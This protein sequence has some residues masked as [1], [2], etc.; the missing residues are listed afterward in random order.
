MLKD[1]MFQEMF[2][3]LELN[4]FEEAKILANYQNFADG[5]VATI[6]EMGYMSTADAV[7]KVPMAR[8]WYITLVEIFS[9]N[10]VSFS[11]VRKDNIVID[12]SKLQYSIEAVK[13]LII[14]QELA[15]VDAD[16]GLILFEKRNH[17]AKW[18]CEAYWMFRG[19]KKSMLGEYYDDFV[20]CAPRM[21]NPDDA[22]WKKISFLK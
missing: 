6:D 10:N 1:I 13:N 9:R 20:Q 3:N 4:S 18:Y 2:R 17:P 8:D 22:M 15:F 5:K 21:K 16:Q 14:A 11:I 7:Y 12:F 19:V